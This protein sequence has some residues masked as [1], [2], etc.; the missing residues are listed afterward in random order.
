VL[1]PWHSENT[2]SCRVSVR[3]H[4]ALQAHCFGCGQTGDALALITAV[5][6]LDLRRDTRA[7]LTIGA[8]LA[9]IALDFG[10]G[11]AGSAQTYQAP[12]PRPAPPR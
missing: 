10:P 1:C 5:H 2:P 11:G 12:A 4:G 6:R 7:I 9:G 8:D 3:D